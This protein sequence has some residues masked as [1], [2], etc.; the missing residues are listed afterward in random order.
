[1]VIIS[2]NLIRKMF[3]KLFMK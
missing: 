2:Q 1:M 3:L